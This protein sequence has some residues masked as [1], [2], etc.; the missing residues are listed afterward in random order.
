MEITGEQELTHNMRKDIDE[1]EVIISEALA[2]REGLKMMARQGW[3][4]IEVESDSQELTKIIVGELN[5]PLDVDVIVE[6]IR[7]QGELL[8]ATF[9]YV[10]RTLNNE[11]HTI[12]HWI[13]GLE[14]EPR[15][16][17]TPPH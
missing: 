15:W 4:N 16:F 9:R 7:Q 1:S 11:A 8:D 13:C 5:V 10:R 2:I 3:P 6:D 17:Q 12:T 14:D